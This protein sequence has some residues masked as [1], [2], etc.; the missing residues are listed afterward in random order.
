MNRLKKIIAILFAIT[1]LTSWNL[2]SYAADNAFK[3]TFENAFYGG[4]VGVLVGGALMAF[5]KH[6]EDHLNYLAYG[7]ASG[8]L[9]GATYGIIKTTRSLAE[10]E[11]GKVKFAVPT[12]MPEPQKHELTGQTKI[13]VSA[14]LLRYNF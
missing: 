9:A 11:N 3:D 12:I 8:V 6:P 4:L 10:Y 5:T 14:Q 2:P 1:I 13:A 7:A